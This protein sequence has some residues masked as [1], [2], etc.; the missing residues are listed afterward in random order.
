MNGRTPTVESIS[1]QSA[2]G[3]I[4]HR[5]AEYLPVT[6]T[7][8][9][10][11]LN[12]G[13]TPLIPAKNFV[14]AIGGKFDLYI[15]YEA[16][17]PTC[18]FKDRGM[19]MAVT[20]AKERGA[21]V[22]ICAS[23]GNTSASAAAYAARAKM[24]C[25]VLLPNGKIALGKLA[26]ALMYGA[27]TIAIEG[28]FD[29][30]LRIVRELGE[31]GKV[32]VVNSIN[33]VRIEGQKT[34]AFEIC[35]ALGDAPDF[36][37][38]PVGNAGNITAYWKGYKE[39]QTAGKSD[40]LPRMF[41]FQAAGSA[42]IVD[43]HPIEDPQTIAT[44]IRIGNPA[45]WKGANAALQESNGYIGK[46]TDEEILEAYKMIARTEGIFAEPASTAPLAGLIRCVREGLIPE[47]SLI[48]ATLTG[49]G[50]K[51]PDCAIKTAG[52]EP[53]I[54]PPTKEAVMQV[55]GL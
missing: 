22:V 46:V 36:H 41:G 15:K 8:P 43:G 11:T 35:D 26:Q 27:T 14:E 55:I 52:F 1:S 21:S 23:T 33:P 3:G 13:N 24:K 38:L 48:T 31:T 9:I 42:P 49:H 40:T 44:A 7:T 5:Y 20:K 51:D 12:E 45:S 39:Y 17:N 19:T 10:V 54:A 32:E 34:A 4:I 50:L 2:W 25:V 37:F 47:G 29:E 16:L 30:A 53:I 28:N 18:S 6:E